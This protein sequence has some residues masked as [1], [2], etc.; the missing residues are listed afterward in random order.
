NHERNGPE[1]RGREADEAPPLANRF[2][3][4]SEIAVLEIPDPAVNHPK[5]MGRRRLDEVGPLDQRHRETPE[6]GGPRPAYPKDPTTQN[7]KIELPPLQLPWIPA[8]QI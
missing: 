2:A 4:P 1:E 7:G 6:C 3:D 5:G 8:H